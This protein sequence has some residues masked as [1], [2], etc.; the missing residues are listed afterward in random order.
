M[1]FAEGGDRDVGGVAKGELGVA[2]GAEGV[3]GHVQ[4]GDGQ[5]YVRGNEHL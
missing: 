4:R 1:E 2:V 3:E 5:L